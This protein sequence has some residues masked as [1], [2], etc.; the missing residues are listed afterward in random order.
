MEEDRI[1]LSMDQ[2]Y[3]FYEEANDALGNLCQLQTTKLKYHGADGRLCVLGMCQDVTETVRIHR[4]NAASKEAYEKAKEAY[5]KFVEI[6]D[7][8]EAENKGIVRTKRFSL[9]PMTPEE[10]ILQMEM[11]E[12]S[13]FVYSDPDTGKANIVY[14]RKDGGYGLLITE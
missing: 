3:I 12:H 1:A 5:D 8:E 9:T 4:E 13:F 6:P 11:L 14:K 10:A 2:P 7:T